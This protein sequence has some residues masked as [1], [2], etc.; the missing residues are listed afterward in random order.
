MLKIL[1]AEDRGSTNLSWL[2]SR[3]SFSFGG[4]YDPDYMGFE[5]LR[6]INDD[7]VSPGAGFGM[8]PHHDMEIITYVIAGSL[9]HKD[10]MGNGSIIAKGDVQRMSAGTG[11]TH[12]EFNPSAAEEVHFLQIWFL[13]EQIGAQPGYEQKPFSS[14]EKQGRFKLLASKAGRDGSLSL[15]QDVDMSAALINGSHEL[16]YNLPAGRAAWVQ[17]A[18]GAVNLNGHDLKAGDGVAVAQEGVLEFKRGDNAEVI[19]FDMKHFAG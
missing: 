10:S 14:Q 12:S 15:L 11:V 8:H 9:E 5:S 3:H 4:Y 13:P 7:K 18:G 2:H 17:I 6:V 16:G 1:K 19:I